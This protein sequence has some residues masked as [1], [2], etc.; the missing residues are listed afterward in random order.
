VVISKSHDT[1]IQ[2]LT[3][4]YSSAPQDYFRQV[5]RAENSGLRIMES[6]M[7]Y[8]CRTLWQPAR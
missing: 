2:V 4:A 5:R 1:P 6:D 7:Q 3:I 8:D